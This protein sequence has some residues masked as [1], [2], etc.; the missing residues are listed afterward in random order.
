MILST[1]AAFAATSGSLFMDGNGNYGIGTSAPLAG[2]HIQRKD[3]ATTQ[4]DSYGLLLENTTP[5]TAAVMQYS[6]GIVLTGSGW[7]QD[8][9]AGPRTMKWRIENRPQAD[10]DDTGSRLNFSY[11]IGN[12]AY[13]D[14]DVFLEIDRF[15]RTWLTSLY[16][17]VSQME[18]LSYLVVDKTNGGSGQN[19]LT[20]SS[21]GDTANTN[22]TF[23]GLLNSTGAAPT[24]GTM[25]YNGYAYTGTI[26]QTG[27]ASGITRGLYINPTLTSAAD[28]RGIETNIAS[29]AGR[30]QIYAGGTA[31]SYFGGNVG[32]GTTVPIRTLDVAGDVGIPT[33]GVVYKGT[34]SFI[35]NFQHPDGGTAVPAGLNTFVG[36]GA[37]NFTMGSTAAGDYE[38]SYNAALGWHALNANTTGFD[39]TASGYATLANNT[40]GSGNT[41]NGSA[42]LYNNDTGTWNTGFGG[43]VLYEN[44]GGG[45][46]AV[47]GL[48]SL[49][50]NVNGNNNT[51]MGTQAGGAGR[52]S[53]TN[54]D[55]QNTVALGYRAG[56]MLGTG[57]NNILLGFQA[58]D[59]LTTGD[60]NIVLGYDINA[61]TATSANTLN[62]GNLI[63]G[64]GLD[65]TGATIATGNIG[66]GTNAPLS[67]L[68]VG[69]GTNVPDAMTITGSDL[70]V[71]GNI[72]FDGRIYGDGSGLTN[73]AS[74]QWTTNGTSIY[75]NTGNVGIGTTIPI[76]K[77]DVNG[78]FS[79]I[80]PETSLKF[81]VGVASTNRLQVY[82]AKPSIRFLD[83]GDNYAQVGIGNLSLGNYAGVAVNDWL[84][85]SLIT[86]GAVGIGTSVPDAALHVG[87][88]EP[89]AMSSTGSDLYVKGNIEFDGRIYGDGSG[90]TGVGGITGLT[91]NYVTKA[92]SATAIGNSQ[93]FDDGTNVGVGTT[94]PGQKL[95]VRSGHAKINGGD[96]Y[97][98]DV[99]G[100]TPTILSSYANAQYLWMIQPTTRP[101]LLIADELLWDRQVAIEYTPGTTGAG[102]GLLQIGQILKNG[103]STFTHGVTTLFTNGIE[104]MRITN[105][106]NVGIGTTIPNNTIQV[107]NLI[108]FYNTDFNTKIGYTA[109][110]NIISGAR[111]NT[112]LGYEAGLSGSGTSTAAAD[113]NT[114]VGYQA[115]SANTTGD[116]NTAIG[117]RALA[118]NTTGRWNTALGRIAMSTHASG[119]DN[120]VVGDAA[121]MVSTQGSQNLAIGA[122]VLMTNRTASN[123]TAVGYGA[124][125]NAN[126]TTTPYTS[127]SVA[128]GYSALRGSATPANNTG[129]YNTA[130]GYETLL[131]YTSG[132]NNT[133]LGY[134]AGYVLD[135]GYNNVLLGYRAGD[136]MTAGNNNIVIGYDINAPTA[137][138]A[139]TLNIG[140]LIFGTGLD[141][142]SAT[143]STGNIGIGTNA[144]LAKLHVGTG[145]NVPDAMTITGSDLY[146]KGNIEFDGRIYGDGS[147]LTNL[148][149]SQWSTTGSDIYYDTGNVGIGT[150]NPKASLSITPTA[151]D[152][153]KIILNDDGTYQFGLR[154]EYLGGIQL[155]GKVWQTHAVFEAVERITYN[156]PSSD[157]V[158]FGVY[159]GGNIGIG[160]ET[161]LSLLH[162]FG[163][164][165]TTGAVVSIETGD[166]AIVANDMAGTIAF[167]GRDSA[168]RAGAY[169]RA[170]A[171]G[172]WT[173]DTDRAPTALQFFTQA[174][175]DTTT[176]TT[177]RMVIDADGNVGI[178]TT[179][180]I[181]TLDLFADTAPIIT[182]TSAGSGQQ[183][184]IQI[185]LA[186]NASTAGGGPSFLFFADNSAGAKRYLGR[187]SAVWENGTAGSEAAAFLFTA[188]SGTSDVNATTERMRITSNGNV[189]IN[190]SA[191]L[192]RLVVAGVGQ[193]T[194]RAFEID[195]SLYNPKVVVLDN[196]N[197]GIG[198]TQPR[199]ALDVSG[200]INTYGATGNPANAGTAD[201]AGD[202]LVVYEASDWRS[203]IGMQSTG[204]YL[205]ATGVN[206]GD[207]IHFYSSTSTPSERMTIITSGNVGIG[208]TSPQQKLEVRGGSIL[209]SEYAVT[210]AASMTVDWANGNQQYISLNQAGHTIS[211][212]NYKVG[213]VLRLILCQS[214]AS[215]TVTTWDTSISWASGTAPTLTAT[216]GQCDIV[217]F[218]CT[219][220]KG[221]VRNFGTM[222]SNF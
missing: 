119:N 221:S 14:S 198:S 155:F 101:T 125:M 129:N 47:L 44:R 28:F 219:Y 50:Y 110:N 97:L 218:V 194:S 217:S 45:S 2:L 93:I 66:I 183:S 62:I 205:Q 138:S 80:D 37:G 87:G 124:M 203:A 103:P 114:A 214:G 111:Y 41:A 46:N 17:R 61:P 31:Q 162:V 18:G 91:T 135:T 200:T 77:L 20:L 149:S 116:N 212:S 12:A 36:L 25:V 170:L 48:Q 153:D 11:S 209:G 22:G 5:A 192:A 64:T 19:V 73:L 100:Q 89:N 29:G 52:G 55:L 169:I 122:D 38:G 211:F 133:V 105:T 207:G 84:T 167:R 63:F 182:R 30:N 16:A 186:N 76:A 7:R 82:A 108:S 6:P 118:A 4:D 71:K 21:S 85:T 161:P 26:N 196:G 174:D 163:G 176:L 75:Y 136:N 222:T 102:A 69:T 151:D 127:Y 141:G 156:L 98:A 83:S 142:T 189:G 195:D 51:V 178:G 159:G 188:R 24:S 60:N 1:S 96:L 172:T 78:S 9:P 79:A 104:R 15:G 190:T 199:S 42:V 109:G 58:G 107:A 139:N 56:Y 53:T 197:V 86:S 150:Y 34:E 54:S 184:A 140:N 210:A 175:S 49:Y 202:R 3:I 152:V 121:M 213:Q 191:P 27:G 67:K 154:K 32:I 220:A 92:T 144:P 146:V 179:S 216:S 59:N 65:G 177:P 43:S 39:N 201:S 120:T 215:R 187:L 94:A 206:A 145:T 130:I 148:S 143:I 158:R 81:T 90:L 185:G 33:T 74:S 173:A 147:G 126:D 204:L 131:N 164:T 123:V 106:G 117:A 132:G 113:Y 8:A 88:G 68:H 99:A 70:Y 72:E 35:H 112:F 128:V 165:G 10:W 137:T 40:T 193:T 181:A 168:T 166:T 13:E 157:V 95:E 171:T 180:P 160:T 23:Y 57:D 115:L 134:Q 208:S